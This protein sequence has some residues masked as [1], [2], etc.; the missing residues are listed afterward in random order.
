MLEQID[1]CGGARRGGNLIGAGFDFEPTPVHAQIQLNA[2]R[3][4]ERPALAKLRQHAAHA[5]AGLDIDTQGLGAGPGPH[6]L[7]LQPVITPSG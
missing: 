5:R 2:A 4:Q 3:P 1:D 7:I 6:E